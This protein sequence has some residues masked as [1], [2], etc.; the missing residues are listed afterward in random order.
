MICLVDS[1]N[2]KKVARR[3]HVYWKLRVANHALEFREAKFLFTQNV[4]SPEFVL[5]IFYIKNI[6]REERG[7]I[8]KA[9]AQ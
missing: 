6:T 8:N 5:F 7:E 9:H 1:I 2:M 4:V 3:K